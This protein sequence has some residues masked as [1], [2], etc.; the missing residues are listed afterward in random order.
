MAVTDWMQDAFC[1]KSSI[2]DWFMAAFFVV[3]T[4][5]PHPLIDR[6]VRTEWTESVLSLYRRSLM[7][8]LCRLIMS[9]I[10]AA[11]VD[12][13]VRLDHNVSEFS[14]RLLSQIL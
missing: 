4:G 5:Q 8:Q 3:C 6:L 10:T 7:Q 2:Q 14:R 9:D 1:G 11:P 13:G 12:T